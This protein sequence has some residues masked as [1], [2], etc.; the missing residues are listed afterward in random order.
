MSLAPH[1]PKKRQYAAG[2]G[3]VY[4]GSAEVPQS[5]TDIQYLS[6]ESPQVIDAA[7]DP[8]HVDLMT[9]PPDP[10]D[11]RIPSPEIRLPPGSCHLSNQSNNSTGSAYHSSTLNAVP[12]TESLLHDIKIP[13]GF[14]ISPHRTLAEG[15]E[16]VPVVDDGVIARCQACRAYINPYV[17]F[18]DGGHRWRCALCA[19]S[20]EVPQAFDWSMAVNQPSD[21]YARAELNHP[22]VD[23]VA[24]A[25]YVRSTPQAPAYVFLVDVSLGAV[26]SGMFATAIRTI[27]ENLD[28]LPNDGQRTK[29]AII[30]YDVGLYFFSLSQGADEF[31][32]LV[33]SDLEEA[34][35][36]RPAHE[37]LVN[38][39]E[40]RGPL[41]ALL[42]RLPAM[43]ADAPVLESATGPALESALALIG[44]AG[45]KI[46]LLSA[47]APT[48]GKGALD[49][50]QQP[51]RDNKKEPD[52]DKSASAFYHAFAIACVKACVSVDMFI[53]GD[54][55]RGVA[56]LTLLSQYT[57]GQTLYYPAFNTAEFEDVVKFV[58][59]FGRVLAM[60]IMLEAEMR[61]RC[62]R[63]ISVKSMHGNF[64][65]QGTARVIMPAIPL[66][67]SY[68]IQFQID[69]PL[70]GP[71]AVFQ[72][73]LLYT[74]SSGERRIR[75][76]TLAL[77]TTSVTAEVY[78]S[79]D[80]RALVTLVTKQMVQRPS[81]LALEDRRDKILR[82][83]TDMCTAYMAARNSP[84]SELKLLLP[85]NLRM[86]PIL[87]LGL[88]KKIATRLDS[89]TALDMRAYTRVL[90]TAA[91][92][93]QLIRYIY[94]NVY[95]LHNMPE[96]VGFL[97][98]EGTL[99]MPTPLPLTSSWW[100][101][102]GLYLFEDGHAVHLWVGRDA[103]PQLIIDVFGVQDYRSLRSGKITLPEV[104]T[105]ISQRIRAIIGKIRE[106]RGALYYPSVYV[107][108][109]D[110]TSG[111]TG[112]R[113]AVAQLF[114][115][116]RTDELRV[117]YRQFL[118]KIYGK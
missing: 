61:V 98:A 54:R 74:T 85:A 22:I 8:Q 106:R 21:R 41:E 109:D 15:E 118:V 48:R 25:E 63:G 113:S 23:F 38:L 1:G 37:L 77:P 28:A 68:A 49:V 17:Q 90:L 94:P 5:L 92:P 19:L 39:S 102:H 93:S 99:L 50:T 43:F 108:K 56:T 95:C 60:P 30:C 91:P 72:A 111:N 35:V 27:S 97:S 80:V 42:Q 40:A 71:L 58:T 4:Y 2:E 44:P 87:L 29:V 36:P 81:V 96:D 53:F 16:P 83:L 101:P 73:G 66:D 52:A 67:E 76:L 32:M 46:V 14:V 51:G 82:L 11:L 59:E 89:E 10:R 112:L 13:L 26:Q 33:V 116:D 86:L 79:A 104:D 57:S 34:Y 47:S 55:Y 114:I 20:N 64:F 62:S 75:V 105:A 3:H 88:F 70:A 31:D 9:Y 103:V 45:G 12:K 100:E 65:V 110:S 24:T 7:P 78:A 117:S 6:L 18:I 107:V 69:E 115:H 84:N